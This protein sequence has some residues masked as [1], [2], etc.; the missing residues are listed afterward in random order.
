MKNFKKLFA[1]LAVIALLASSVPTA[2]LGN[3][4]YSNELLDAYDYAYSIGI[5]TQSPIENANMN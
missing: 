3:A 2:V 5:T 1:S 4:N